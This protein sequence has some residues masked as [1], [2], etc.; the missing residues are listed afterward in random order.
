[1]CENEH[2]F[3]DRNKKLVNETSLYQSMTLPLPASGA[4]V[5][6]WGPV[7]AKVTFYH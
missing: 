2:S 6:I 3:K 7:H 4:G 5:A 1:M